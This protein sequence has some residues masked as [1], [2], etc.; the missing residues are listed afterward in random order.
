MNRKSICSTRL[1]NEMSGNI[2][3]TG[4]CLRG[5]ISHF[6]NQK[7]DIHLR[8]LRSRKAASAEYENVASREKFTIRYVNILK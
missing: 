4:N 7:D 8:A 6:T 2:G 1:E 5:Q 3:A